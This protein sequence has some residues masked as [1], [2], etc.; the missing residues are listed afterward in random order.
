MLRN[1]KGFSIVEL[2]AIIFISSVII[3]PLTMTLVNNIEINDKLHKR[4]SATSIANGTM[5]A[6]DKLDFE[7]LEIEVSGSVDYYIELN[8]LEC[9][10]ATYLTEADIALCTEIFD[11]TFNNLSLD[12]VH[13][14]VFIY[15]YSPTT[16]EKNSLTSDTNIPQ[17]VRDE[18]S[19]VAAD[20]TAV[21]TLL[22]VTVWV[23]YYEDPIGIIV[24]SGL[25]FSE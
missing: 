6:L 19:L 4:R 22:R 12:N 11:A 5:Y 23:W 7:D 2:L 1:N 9:D 8:S 15:E 16:A 21:T 3:W 17:E 25:L 20:Q 10:N 13:Y 18:I 24:L 14:R